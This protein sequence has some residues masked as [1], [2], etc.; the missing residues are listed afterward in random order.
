MNNILIK[1]GLIITASET[2]QGDL[3]ISDGVIV[4]IGSGLEHSEAQ[5]IDATGRYVLPGGVD[6][7]THLNLTVGGVK[8]GDGFFEGTAAAASGGTTCIVEHPGFGPEGCALQHQIDC[9]L[10]EAAGQAIV[11]YGL[12]GVFQHVNE[13]V[14][15]NM[16]DIVQQGV[17][18]AKVYMTY[19]GRLDDHQI[20]RVLYR[21]GTIGLLTTFH[22]E[23][24]A[25]IGFLRGKYLARGKL[26]PIFHALSRPGYS[27]SEAVQRIM[28]LARAANNAPVYI[29]HLST[30]P[31]LQAIESARNNGQTVY[32]EVCPQHLL[33]D[34]S[35]YEEPDNNGLKYIMAP[36]ARKQE[37]CAALWRGLRDGSV[38]VVAT[39]HCSFNFADKLALGRHD[40]SKCPGGIPGVETRVPLMFSEGVLQKR[41]SLNR[42]VELVATAPAR[43]MGLYPRKGTLMPGADA[44]VVIFDPDREKTITPDNLCHNADYSPYEGMKV[45]GWPE[46]TMVRGRVVM[47]QDRITTEKGWGQYINRQWIIDD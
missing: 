14:L 47:Q 43:I 44:D 26:E 46:I 5:V 29:V 16:T 28:A 13:S 9:Y 36:P 12:H 11:D 20:L 22:A 3:M 31:G 21:A 34:D 32:A 1:N 27:E 18:S 2:F 35:C 4:R 40:F 33:L 42:F 39:D 10:E 30:A 8:V 6:V 45:R 38:D 17:S 19:D 23:N 24:D 37:D 41:L 7:H 15:D 25:I